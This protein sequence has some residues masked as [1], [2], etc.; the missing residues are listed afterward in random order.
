LELRGGEA[1]E[2]GKRKGQPLRRK[3]SVNSEEKG[4]GRKLL[5]ETVKNSGPF[6]KEGRKSSQPFCEKRKVAGLVDI[7]GIGSQAI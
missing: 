3:F 5:K 6:E 2:S 4:R 7:G 1:A